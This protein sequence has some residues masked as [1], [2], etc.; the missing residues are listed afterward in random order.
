MK[1]TKDEVRWF[2][3]KRDWLRPSDYQSIFE[4]TTS[5]DRHME[6][7]WYVAGYLSA[8]TETHIPERG[9]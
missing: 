3:V 1:F 9:V 2:F 7:C 6:L 8:K 4:K 5:Q